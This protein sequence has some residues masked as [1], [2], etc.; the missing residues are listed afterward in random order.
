MHNTVDKI[1]KKDSARTFGTQGAKKYLVS[2]L[3]DDIIS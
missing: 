3:Q 1:E 2:L